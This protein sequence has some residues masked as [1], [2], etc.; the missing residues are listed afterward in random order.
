MTS[1]LTFQNTHFDVIEQK[2]RTW[3]TATQISAALGYKTDDAV[4][5][6]YRRNSDE[7]SN[8]MTQT[9]KLT[10]SGN[11]QKTVRIFS[12]RGAHLIAMFSR[13]PIA[14]EFRKWVLDVL[15][16][17][18]RPAAIVP[19]IKRPQYKAVWPTH[20]RSNWNGAYFPYN[21]EIIGNICF[22][23]APIGK[24]DKYSAIFRFSNEEHQVILVG[25]R[26]GDFGYFE[27]TLLDEVW[28]FAIKFCGRCNS[29]CAHI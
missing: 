24:T 20:F 27:S 17:E 29:K 28:E 4:S 11:Y 9:V 1:A 19:I 25:E 2:K 7:F 3:L 8:E 14:K 21:G 23:I 10:A 5:R 18:S 12:L 22:E 16:Q 15:D 26:L 13:T 6:I